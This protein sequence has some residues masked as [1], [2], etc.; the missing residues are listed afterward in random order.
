MDVW[1]DMNGGE[2]IEIH[3]WMEVDARIDG[4]MDRWLVGWLKGWMN[5][6]M[7]GW[8]D[9][10]ENM[11]IDGRMDGLHKKKADKNL[12]FVKMITSEKMLHLHCSCFIPARYLKPVKANE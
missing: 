1:I 6:G 3:G 2:C 10:Y 5:G 12:C 7:D 11:E 4:W 9:G 8:M